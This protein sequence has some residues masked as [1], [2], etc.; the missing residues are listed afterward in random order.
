M[1]LKVQGVRMELLI[2]FIVLLLIVG[3]IYH[4]GKR[5]GSRQGYAAGRSRFRR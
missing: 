4:S 3:G 2:G 5:T 1:Q